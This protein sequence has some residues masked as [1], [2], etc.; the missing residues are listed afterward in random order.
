MDANS[1]TSTYLYDAL[2]R[3]TRRELSSQNPSALIGVSSASFVY[4]TVPGPGYGQLKEV[5]ADDT[6]EGT[7]YDFGY[8]FAG[9]LAS[10]VQT[11]AGRVFP[12][13][14][15]YDAADRVKVW[16]RPGMASNSYGRSYHYNGTRMYQVGVTLM[17]IKYEDDG[18][19]KEYSPV[20]WVKVQKSYDPITTRLANIKAL[21]TNT[22]TGEH[23]NLDLTFDGLG[24]NT[25]FRGHVNNGA[26]AVEMD[27]SF[28]YDG[29]SRLKT[30][31]GEWEK[32]HGNNN[33]VTWTFH[34]DP[35]G[36]L[37]SQT[38]APLPGQSTAVYSRT[39]DYNHLTKPRALTAFSETIGTSTANEIITHDANGGVSNV[40]S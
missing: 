20:G 25:V 7:S 1:N 19:I 22:P 33:R 36:N 39:W 11:T 18:R 8:D 6:T 28:T 32:P 5:N 35:L 26:G 40:V 38:S 14:Y 29:M 27:R 13:T 12:T 15:E 34:Y 37:R 31:L 17:D 10:E 30:A 4:E 3:V 9:R 21:K 16:Q 23:M 2:G 24:R